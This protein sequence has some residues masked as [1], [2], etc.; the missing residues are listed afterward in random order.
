MGSNRK[1][2]YCDSNIGIITLRVT[3][4]FSILMV[5]MIFPSTVS[6]FYLKPIFR[7][8]MKNERKKEIDVTNHHEY[9]RKTNKKEL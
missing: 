7:I 1:V 4:L 9:N 5:P 6:S 2:Q 3:K 8:R